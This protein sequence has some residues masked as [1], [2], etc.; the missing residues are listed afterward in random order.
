M[1]KQSRF[2]KQLDKLELFYNSEFNLKPALAILGKHDFDR[3]EFGFQ[4]VRDNTIKFIRNISFATP[5]ALM[6]FIQQ[7]IPLSMYVGAIYSEGP[8]YRKNKSIQQLQWIKRELVFDLDLTEYDPVRPCDCRGKNKMC[9][10]CWELINV[11]MVWIH[12]TLKEDFGVKKISWF[13]SGRRGVHAWIQDP[14]FSIL[15]NDQRASIVDYLAFFKGDG[16]TAKFSLIA[17]DNPFYLERVVKLIYETYI[18]EANVDQLL[19][20]GFK[21]ERAM[22][23]LNQRDKYGI[24]REFLQKYVFSDFKGPN[25]SSSERLPSKEAIRDAILLRW[26]PRID[27]AVTIDLRR[28]LRLPGSIHGETGRIVRSIEEDELDYFDPFSEESIY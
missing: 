3:R 10:I 15:N 21:K 8:D 26:S 7:K 6:K 17:K 5:E 1:S 28:I 20:L 25:I 16:N 19:N 9:N 22:Y 27:T 11:S 14:E 24:S 4:V 18:R 13:F 2:Q 23:I 12:E